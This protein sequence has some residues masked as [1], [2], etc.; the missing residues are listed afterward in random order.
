MLI[1]LLTIGAPQLGL[2][3]LRGAVVGNDA[4]QLFHLGVCLS[5]TVNL[6]I[7]LGASLMSRERLIDR[8]QANA[9]MADGFAAIGSGNRELNGTIGELRELLQ[10]FLGSTEAGLGLA[11]FGKS[12]RHL[13]DDDAVTPAVA[14]LAERMLAGAIGASSARNVIALALAGDERDASNVR[15]ILDEAADA[16]HFSREIVHTAFNAIDQGISVVDSDLRL[17]A[18][19]ERY[20]ELFRYPA[21]EIYVG[22][23]LEELIALGVARAGISPQEQAAVLEERLGLMRRRKRSFSEQEWPDGLIVRIVGRPL[24]TGEYVTSFT[25]VTEVRAASR[26]LAAINEELEQRVNART[27][28]LTRVNQALVEAKALADH[29]TSAQNRFVAAAS[30]DLLQPMHAARLY[31]GAAQEGL[32]DD[33]HLKHL[34]VQA[35]HSVEAA[36]RLLKALLNL[37][38]IEIGGIVPELLPVDLNDLLT[39]LNREF[40]PLAETKGLSLHIVRTDAW[41]CSNPD[42]LRSVLQ[43]LLGNAIHYTLTGRIVVC[44]R[45]EGDALR[46]EVR[47]SGPG[48]AYEARE[49]IFR[50]FTRLPETSGR[51]AGTGLGLAIAQRICS[52]LDH[53]LTVRSDKGRG[54]VFS[55]RIPRAATSVPRAPSRNGAAALGGLRILCVEDNAEILRAECML[56]ERW[57]AIVAPAQS[58]AEAL[59]HAAPWDVVIADYHLGSGPDGLDLY[60]VLPS[61]VAHKLLLT[62]DISDRVRER[63]AA[64]GVTILPKPV[65]PASLRAFLTHAAKSRSAHRVAGAA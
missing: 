57:G 44:V 17:I 33:A 29:V 14:R 7:Y 58:V 55:V 27:H 34:L 64:L 56:L 2:T 26:A 3:G 51:A 15:H 18:W 32:R 42:L 48:I 43:N 41:A 50:E 24:S 5:L 47:D 1:W 36:D 40:A 62:A 20:V 52:A 10:R 30:H 22:R 35:D 6:A 16:I 49:L 21:S 9:F 25:D 4:R 38:R 12:G 13:H 11:D 46:I 59:D 31:L 8:I 39:A 60:E 28:E 23:P 53:R 54:S 45:R 61:A 63:A 37:S 19:N 65:N